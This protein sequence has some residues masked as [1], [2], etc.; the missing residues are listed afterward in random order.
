M[1]RSFYGWNEKVCVAGKRQGCSM[2]DTGGAASFPAWNYQQSH[3]PDAGIT[4]WNMSRTQPSISL[5]SIHV[6]LPVQHYITCAPQTNQTNSKHRIQLEE[7]PTVTKLIDKIPGFSTAGPLI[8]R[9]T[10]IPFWLLTWAK[11][12]KT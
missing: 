2:L 5:I 7:K 8:T 3:Q 12:E 9:F 11:G 6:H 10:V 4:C 1:L